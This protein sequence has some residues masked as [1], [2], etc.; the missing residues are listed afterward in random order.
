M[1]TPTLKVISPIEMRRGIMRWAMQMTSGLVLYGVILF[2]AAGRLNW[3]AGW[4]YLGLNALTQILT[5][6]VLVPRQPG[7]LVER[8][9]IRQGTKQ[10]DRFL[11]PAVALIGPFAIM[12]TAGLDARFAWSPQVQNG[13]WLAGLIMAFCCQ[14]FVLWAMSSNPFFSTTVRIQA[15]RSHGVTNSGPYMLV[16]HPGYLDAFLFGLVAPIALTSWWAYIPALLTNLLIILR[17]KL[18]DSTL[19]KDLPGYAEYSA[20]VRYRLFPEIW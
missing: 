9:K 19:Q 3:M 6:I 20:S 1:T 16:R 18:E 17:T 7:M 13:L 14:M 10:W 5:T 2:L 8:P 11:A 15:E 4:A 12:I